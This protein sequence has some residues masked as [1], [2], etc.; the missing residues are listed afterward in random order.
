MPKRAAGPIRVEPPIESGSFPLANT[1]GF[2]ALER[3]MLVGLV[4]STHVALEVYCTCDPKPM[5]KVYGRLEG[6][7]EGAH[8][9]PCFIF[10]ELGRGEI[11]V[12]PALD[13]TVAGHFKTTDV[14][15]TR[16][17]G[18][19]QIGGVDVTRK[20]RTRARVKALEVAARPA[21]ILVE[22]AKGAEAKCACGHLIG[23]HDP[24]SKCVCPGFHTSKKMERYARRTA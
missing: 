19:Q 5:A 11:E 18:W 20:K 4:G 21:A 7:R 16:P 6:T 8:E 23:D 10:N 9:G 15:I 22:R 2:H 13:A 3:T 17:D 1:P 14:W 12:T 24:C